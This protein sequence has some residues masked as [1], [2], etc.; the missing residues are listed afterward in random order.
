MNAVEGFKETRVVQSRGRFVT[1][2]EVRAAGGTAY[3]V[4]KVA[5][6]GCLLRTSFR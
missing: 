6:S 2:A 4:D 1:G 5:R 3:K